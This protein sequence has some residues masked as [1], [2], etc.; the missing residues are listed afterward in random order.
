MPYGLIF[1]VV[2]PVF[3][4]A[5]VVGQ[6]PLVHRLRI[7]DP[8]LITRWLVAVS[9][10]LLVVYYWVF[11]VRQRVLTKYW[12]SLGQPVMYNVLCYITYLLTY[13]MQQS[14]S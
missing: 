7:V 3:P 8:D 6:V 5:D 9:T 13:S 4:P 2:F 11:L 12:P 14:P 10:I 1:F